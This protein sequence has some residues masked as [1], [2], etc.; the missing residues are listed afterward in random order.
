MTAA[1]FMIKALFCTLIRLL[2]LLFI[3]V[4]N[5]VLCIFVVYIT[6]LCQLFAAAVSGCSVQLASVDLL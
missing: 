4:S 5:N 1:I 2:L 3:Y 6:R